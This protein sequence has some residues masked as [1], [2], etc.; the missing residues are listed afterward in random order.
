MLIP[1]QSSINYG[2]LSD[3]DDGKSSIEMN[4]RLL[5]NEKMKRG[6][7]VYDSDDHKNVVINKKIRGYKNV[8]NYIKSGLP[9]NISTSTIMSCVI[10]CGSFAANILSIWYNSVYLVYSQYIYNHNDKISNFH[11]E[12]L[13]I[14]YQIVTWMEF[15]ILIGLCGILCYLLHKKSKLD[16]PFSYNNNIKCTIIDCIQLIRSWSSFK[17]FAEFNPNHLF[18]HFAENFSHHPSRLNETYIAKYKT[19]KILQYQ[20]SKLQY[21]DDNDNNNNDE[22]FKTIKDINDIIETDYERIESTDHNINY[23]LISEADDLSDI[24]TQCNEC[25]STDIYRFCPISKNALCAE[26][27]VKKYR[28]NVLYRETLWKT[29]AR[30]GSRMIMY[31]LIIF[32]FL[33]GIVC[34]FLKLAQLAYI[35]EINIL[36]WGWPQYLT[37]IGFLNQVWNIYNIEEIKMDSICHFIFA[38]HNPQNTSYIT[39]KKIKLMNTIKQTLWDKYGRRGLVLAAC[40]DSS[41]LHQLLVT[42]ININSHTNSRL[43]QENIEENINIIKSRS[44]RVIDEQIEAQR[45]F[46]FRKSRE[47]LLAMNHSMW[48]QNHSLNQL[49]DTTKNKNSTCICCKQCIA[50]IAKLKIWAKTRW[51]WINLVDVREYNPLMMAKYNKLRQD[52]KKEQ[53][54]HMNDNETEHVTKNLFNLS[55]WFEKIEKFLKLTFIPIGAILLALTGVFGLISFIIDIIDYIIEHNFSHSSYYAFIPF[56]LL[57]GLMVILIYVMFYRVERKEEKYNFDDSVAAKWLFLISFVTSWTWFGYG[58]YFYIQYFVHYQEIFHRAIFIMF[59]LYMICNFILT[60]WF[61]SLLFAYLIGSTKNICILITSM[62]TFYMPVFMCTVLSFGIIFITHQ[63]SMVRNN[64]YG[65]SMLILYAFLIALNMC[66]VFSGLLHFVCSIIH[67]CLKKAKRN[68]I[69]KRLIFVHYTIKIIVFIECIIYLKLFYFNYNSDTSKISN[70]YGIQD[71]YIAGSPFL[72][73]YGF[74]FI[75]TF[76]PYLLYFL[77]Q[78]QSK[79]FIEYMDNS[80]AL[81]LL[82]IFTAENKKK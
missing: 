77:F 66:Y 31:I 37:F 9:Q 17:L 79:N 61:T 32:L 10:F 47:L 73:V 34:F 8:E 19:F 53:L 11:Q 68:Q 39:Q 57:Y 48:K 69:F 71:F 46:I 52:Q 24:K 27:C 16:E 80:N 40:M 78:F 65:I 43:N 20:L 41:F 35:N 60:V 30:V 44:Q 75:V 50:C 70:K 38:E 26:C 33:F 12:Y 63:V 7:E 45:P 76:F 54:K 58:V 2:A 1:L 64:N 59:D 51:D 22:L 42:N 5:K 74:G 55:L 56:I 14:L 28:F 6:S 81:N 82:Q 15:S 67:F 3:N 29:T 23:K 13:R 62:F 25:Q 72:W 18:K 4:D 21:T 49:D 36:N